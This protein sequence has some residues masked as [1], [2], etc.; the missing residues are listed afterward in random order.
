[1]TQSQLLS[2][3]NFEN[4]REVDVDMRIWQLPLLEL[5]LEL[6]VRHVPSLPLGTYLCALE[7]L[8]GQLPPCVKAFA[9]I[10]QPLEPCG[11]KS[12]EKNTPVCQAISEREPGGWKP[13]K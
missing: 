13:G 3:Q 7:G 11:I 6:L 9:G 2:F 1:M 12:Q 4:Q 5:L 10:S 8:G